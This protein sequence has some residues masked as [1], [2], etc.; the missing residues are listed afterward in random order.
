MQI[1]QVRGSA[2]GA[3]LQPLGSDRPRARDGA[4]LAQP[5]AATTAS[6]TD[7]P[8]PCST[9]RPGG[10]WQRAWAQRRCARPPHRH[11]ADLG[12]VRDS[13]CR[14][15][16]GRVATLPASRCRSIRSSSWRRAASRRAALDT[17]RP[18]VR[19]LRTD[20]P[21]GSAP[22][23]STVGGFAPA[24]E[25]TSSGCSR[26]V[27]TRPRRR[28]E[29]EEHGHVNHDRWHPTVGG[30]A[31]VEH[32]GTDARLPACARRRTAAAA[33]EIIVVDNGSTDGS[34]DAVA[35]ALPGGAAAAQRR[36]PRLRRR[37][38]PGRA[39]GRGPLVVPAQQRHR[40]A[41]RRARRRWSTSWSSIPATAPR[42]RGSSIPTAAVQRACMRFPGLSTGALLRHVLGEASGRARG[43][44]R[45]TS[46]ATSTTCTAATSTS[47]P[48]PAS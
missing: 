32:A 34:A 6:G 23:T 45:A 22:S 27:R 7:A 18:D 47:R 8:A 4:L 43:S 25:S 29:R 39:R 17:E 30:R 26:P 38:Q 28:G 31:V 44:T 15:S 13:R 35:T 48:A 21:T 16:I 5:A 11:V 42:R 10:C 20:R 37:Q 33:R 1:V 12:E 36:E 46:C 14:G 9:T 41:A 19:E 24:R 3:L 40:G 2:A